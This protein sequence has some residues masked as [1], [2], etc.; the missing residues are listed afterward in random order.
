MTIR[1]G[2]SHESSKIHLVL[3]CCMIVNHLPRSDARATPQRARAARVGRPSHYRCPS[4][5]LSRLGRGSP[6][7]RRTQRR[8]RGGARA[9]AAAGRSPRPAAPSSCRASQPPRAAP[10]PI[11]AAR[12]P[13]PR[14][15][16]AGGMGSR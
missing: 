6:G 9:R 12:P 11:R 5:F 1:R 10:L 3:C 14:R 8:R 13:R 16:A 2:P 4:R 15:G 7:R